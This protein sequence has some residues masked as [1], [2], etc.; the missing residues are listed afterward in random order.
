MRVII[1]GSRTFNDYTLLKKCC[2]VYLND[3]SDIKILCGMAKGADALGLR[4]AKEN[5][6][7][8]LE[9]PALWNDFT[10]DKC[11]VKTSKNGGKYNALAGHNR[12]EE[13]AKNAD[14]LICFWDGQSSG[15][16]NMI[17][18]AEKY[19]LIINLKIF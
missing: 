2:D 11:V 1:A 5:N 14:M 10:V 4:Y 9:Y 3:F 18:L 13:M 6:Y 8:V 19:K 17:S 16:R 12:N 15:S 7:E